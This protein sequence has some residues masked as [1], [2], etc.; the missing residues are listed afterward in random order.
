MQTLKLLPQRDTFV[1]EKL[2]KG[3]IKMDVLT[4]ARELAKALQES[5]AYTAMSEAREKNDKNIEE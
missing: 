2:F 1:L 4:K 5:E 3:E